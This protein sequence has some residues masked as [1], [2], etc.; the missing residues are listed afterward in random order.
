MQEP[1]DE[2]QI[3]VQDS[4]SALPP[5]E[6]LIQKVGDWDRGRPEKEKGLLHAGNR[7]QKWA[8]GDC[9]REGR[10]RGK[11]RFFSKGGKC[12]L[13]QAWPLRIQT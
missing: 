10:R 7:R 11:G 5:R 13:C 9:P 1:Q 12:W 2:I 4:L 8:L 6:R 3:L